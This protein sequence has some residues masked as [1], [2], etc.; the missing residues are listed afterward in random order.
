MFKKKKK[1]GIILR[2]KKKKKKRE[3]HR[4]LSTSTCGYCM[5]L[6]IRSL[7]ILPYCPIVLSVILYIGCNKNLAIQN[8]SK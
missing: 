6:L 7:F 8:I 2:K 5:H 1:G 3:Q 4:V